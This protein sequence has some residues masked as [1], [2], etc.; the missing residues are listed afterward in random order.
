MPAFE[1]P[2]VGGHANAINAHVRK[3]TFEIGHQIRVGPENIAVFPA[4]GGEFTRGIL[5]ELLGTGPGI[6]QM[7]L[8]PIRHKLLE[9]FSG[10]DGILPI[11]PANLLELFHCIDQVVCRADSALRDHERSLGAHRSDFLDARAG[12]RGVS[13]GMD[14][15]H[16]R[17][18]LC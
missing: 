4:Q 11:G 17:I 14:I 6:L 3:R 7:P 8:L 15:A 16:L 18:P 12:V 2:E 5:K 9:L 1:V 10:K 13:I